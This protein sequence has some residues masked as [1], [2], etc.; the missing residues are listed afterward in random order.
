MV[1]GEKGQYG[2]VR[3]I[4]ETG[5]KPKKTPKH[6]GASA[7]ASTPIHTSTSAAGEA[8]YP[9]S[10][11]MYPQSA[12][13]MVGDASR[14]AILD[15]SQEGS[16]WAIRIGDAP[17]PGWG[18]KRSL[19]PEGALENE[20]KRKRIDSG[21]VFQSHHSVLPVTN[22]PLRLRVAFAPVVC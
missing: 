22:W 21:C 11:R 4:E 6:H 17:L 10:T 8:M 15:E 7:S 2:Y 19:S 3:L 5:K 20:H 14:A 18:K 13:I 1:P 16:E 12:P 9:D